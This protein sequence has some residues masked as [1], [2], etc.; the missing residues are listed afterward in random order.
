TILSDNL[1]NTNIAYGSASVVNVTN[2]TN[3]ANIS[4]AIAS[5]NLTCTASGATVTVGATTGTFAVQ[6][7]ATA[8]A[9]GTFANPRGGGSC[10]VDPNNVAPE[11][12][13]GNNS[14]S[15]TVVATAVD[16]TA[17]KANNVS[18]AGTLGSNW[19]WTITVNNTGTTAAT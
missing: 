12:N 17:T 6:F 11:S 3:S 14:C 15:D 5:S 16:L 13:E 7:T 1:P 8:S 19:T 10:G 2:V 9:A 18:G 4:C